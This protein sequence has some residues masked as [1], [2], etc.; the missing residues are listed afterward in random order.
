M[1]CKT[2]LEY[3]GFDFIYD[4]NLGAINSIKINIKANY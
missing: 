2:M 3:G 1:K 4:L